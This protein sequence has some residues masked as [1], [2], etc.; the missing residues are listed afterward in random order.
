M[1]RACLVLLVCA[2]WTSSSADTERVAAHPFPPICWDEASRPDPG[3]R[4]ELAPLVASET[5]SAYTPPS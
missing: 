2:G 3:V 1:K 5:E 4:F